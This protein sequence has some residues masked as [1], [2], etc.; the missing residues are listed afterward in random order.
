MP[1][2]V[3]SVNPNGSLNI[4]VTCDCGSPI[5]HATDAGMFCSNA[6]CDIEKVSNNMMADI[7]SMFDGMDEDNPLA[8]FGKL[9]SNIENIGKKVEDGD[10]D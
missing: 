9:F 8:S 5:T 1:A 3:T 2:N 10:Y 4:S 6:A 7:N